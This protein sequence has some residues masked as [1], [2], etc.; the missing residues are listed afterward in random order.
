MGDQRFIE[1]VFV[2]LEE[3]CQIIRD[4]AEL[5]MLHGIFT[6]DGELERRR[7]ELLKAAEGKPRGVRENLKK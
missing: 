4:Q 3:A 5:M 7:A 2:M 6:D 1:R